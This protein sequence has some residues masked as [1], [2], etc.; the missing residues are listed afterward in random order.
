MVWQFSGNRQL[1]EQ[2]E[3]KLA[4]LL[5]TEG[6]DD[7]EDEEEED[8]EDED[9]LGVEGKIITAELRRM[10]DAL[11]TMQARHDKSIVKSKFSN[12]LRSE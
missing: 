9:P 1:V 10:T 8:K 7:A 6:E 4:R 5:P 3:S 11:R 12:L 2:F